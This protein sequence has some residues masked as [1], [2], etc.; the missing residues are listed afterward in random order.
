M[1]DDQMRAA[2]WALVPVPY[3]EW[4]AL[5]RNEAAKQEYLFGPRS[6]GGVLRIARYHHH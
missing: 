6:P 5:G 1:I 4:R 2:G 3:W